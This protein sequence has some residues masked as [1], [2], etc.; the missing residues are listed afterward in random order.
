MPKQITD[1]SRRKKRLEKKIRSHYL[2]CQQIIQS[3]IESEEMEIEFNKPN[4]LGSIIGN[5]AEHF[6]LFNEEVKAFF[7]TIKTNS[8]P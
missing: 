6:K 7:K 2:N 4:F 8:L 3:V 5:V 1:F